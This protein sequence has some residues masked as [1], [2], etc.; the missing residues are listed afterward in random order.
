MAT[1][2]EIIIR[3]PMPGELGWIIQVHGQYYAETF[4]WYGEFE[5][6]VAKIV[7]DYLSSESRDRQ[8][9]FIAELN[10]QRVCC[11]MLTESSRS[12]GKLRVMFVSADARGKG[13]GSLLIK[14]A[15]H[16]AA[17]AGYEGLS[18][19]T[20][21]NQKT[22]RELYKK[23]GFAMVSSSPNTTFAKGSNDEHWSMADLQQR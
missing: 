7:V 11:I 5:C 22:A 15:L 6:I 21:N 2:N 17:A 3:S 13:I 18:L 23:F 4:G 14:T 19:W 20:T 16:K 9:C 1:E 12:E 10:G 8:A